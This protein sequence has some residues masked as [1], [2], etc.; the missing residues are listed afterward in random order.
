MAK[1]KSH[2]VAILNNIPVGY[3]KNISYAKRKFTLTPNKAEA[4]GYV[5]QDYIQREIDELTKIG[6]SQ[7]YIF[8][9]D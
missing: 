3:I 1:E 9:Y 4:K 5:S 7:G 6:Y 8:M 2:I